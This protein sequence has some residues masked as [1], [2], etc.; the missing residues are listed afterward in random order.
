MIGL[1]FDKNILQHQKKLSSYF[2]CLPVHPPFWF[3]FVFS[4]LKN[5]F[6]NEVHIFM[7]TTRISLSTFTTYYAERVQYVLSSWCCFKSWGVDMLSTTEAK[8]SFQN[9]IMITSS[10]DASVCP[11]QSWRSDG[12][13][14]RLVVG[15]LDRARS[16]VDSFIPYH[17]PHPSHLK[18]AEGL[19]SSLAA[20]SKLYSTR[21][22]NTILWLHLLELDH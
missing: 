22:S 7:M 5:L 12:T 15:G 19:S 2:I 17:Y 9:W 11:H 3:C 6:P 16:S 18:L 10:D 4:F 14:S 13:T 8:P 1:R 20:D 21:F